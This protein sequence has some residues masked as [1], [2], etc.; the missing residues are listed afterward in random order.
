MQKTLIIL[1]HLNMAQ[2][3]LNKALIETVKDEPN[4]TVHDIYATYKN[5]DAIDVAKEQALLLEHE[6]IIFQ[7]PFYWYSTPSLLKEWQDKVLEYGF[8]Y[9]STGDKL[10][11]KP[12][13]IAVTIGAPEE[14]YQPEGFMQATISELLKPLQTMALMTQMTFTSTFKIYGALKISDAELTQKAKEYQGI[15]KTAQWSHA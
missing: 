13:K 11:G 8:A 7:F 4:I 5:A 14:A 2:S 1:T 10:K 6:R 3:R 9:G 15:I 12:F